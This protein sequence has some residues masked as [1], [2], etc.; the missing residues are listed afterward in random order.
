[1]LG[2]SGIVLP[3]S[4]TAARYAIARAFSSPGLGGV[5]DSACACLELRYRNESNVWIQPVALT[6]LVFDEQMFGRLLAEFLFIAFVHRG[7]ATAHALS[8][9][10][11]IE[12]EAVGQLV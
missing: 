8:N 5:V 3:P 10:P 12:L 1:M 7:A 11:L 2:L 6:R 9:R 4:R